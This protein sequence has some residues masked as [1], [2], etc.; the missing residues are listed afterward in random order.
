MNTA[1]RILGL[2]AIA[3]G[4]LRVVDSFTAQSLTATSLAALYF[5]TD[6]LLLLGI[7]GIYWSRRATLG[8]AGVIGSAAFAIGIVLIRISAFGVLGTNEYQL[9]AAIALLGL[10]ILSAEE[11][12]RG[13]GISAAAILWLAAVAFGII[14]TLGVLAPTMTIAAGVTF[15]AGFFLAG[16]QV[17]AVGGAKNKGRVDR[18]GPWKCS[19]R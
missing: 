14:G 19:K 5:A 2:S 18:R 10:A 16:R 1:L 15:G 17:V 8:I 11:L 4:T 12:L 6:V 3:G 13:D 9:G 7:A